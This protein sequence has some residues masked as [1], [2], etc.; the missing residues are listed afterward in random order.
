MAVRCTVDPSA[1]AR[2]RSLTA[3]KLYDTARDRAISLTHVDTTEYGSP[4]AHTTRGA[5]S[6]SR[7][8]V[9][10]RGG[11]KDDP[12]PVKRASRGGTREAG[13]SPPTG[14]AKALS[15]GAR[16]FRVFAVH[17]LS[18]PHAPRVRALPRACAT[19]C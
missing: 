1:P 8:R 12:T 17:V 13:L 9:G 4:R 16:R 3:D 19:V 14:S 7:T 2:D 5:A 11:A 15:A 18:R 6:G 10:G